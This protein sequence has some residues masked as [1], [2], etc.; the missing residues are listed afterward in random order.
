MGRHCRGIQAN[1]P[2]LFGQFLQ[3]MSAAR[4]CAGAVR[5]RG[6]HCG[7]AGHALRLPR[8]EHRQLHVDRGAP[9]LWQ[10]RGRDLLVFE[11]GR[12]PPGQFCGAGH[13]C[14]FKGHSGGQAPKRAGDHRPGQ[15]LPPAAPDAGGPPRPGR[16]QGHGRQP[17]ALRHRE[18]LLRQR[19]WDCGAAP[20][21][22][23]DPPTPPQLPGRHLHN[24][25]PLHLHPAE[26]RA[27]GDGPCG[28]SAGRAQ[29]PDPQWLYRPR[30]H[31][32][33]GGR[34]DLPHDGRGHRGSGL[35]RA[36]RERGTVGDIIRGLSGLHHPCPVPPG[37][38]GG[39]SAADQD[40]VRYGGGDRGNPSGRPQRKSLR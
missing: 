1:S 5:R 22:S 6:E 38:S 27:E 19:E 12:H 35:R 24:G 16:Y 36:E 11:F 37:Q 2:R 40:A 26:P 3:R 39:E 13:Q 32:A 15:H 33:R 29:N 9:V 7:R 34:Q 14:K 20:R 18:G 4:K 31:V 10:P 30:D 8:R 28:S 21:Q 17:L 23:H 25:L